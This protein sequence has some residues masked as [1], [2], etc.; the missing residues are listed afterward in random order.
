M[1]IPKGIKGTTVDEIFFTESSVAK[2][3]VLRHLH[4]DIFNQNSN[5]IEVKKKLAEEA[6]NA[7]GNAV[8]N[9][10]YGQKTRDWRALFT[11]MRWDT[12]EWYGEGDAIM[13]K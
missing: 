2:A 9:F 5:L 13:L 4:I 1:K 6:K 10:H 7:G 8:M 12:E 11:S 3:S